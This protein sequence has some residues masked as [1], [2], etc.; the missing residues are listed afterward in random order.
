MQIVETAL[1]LLANIERQVAVVDFVL[2]C[3]CYNCSSRI[4][5]SQ[6]KSHKRVCL[7]LIAN[8]VISDVCVLFAV[9]KGEIGSLTKM[10]R[11]RQKA[12]MFL[13]KLKRKPRSRLAR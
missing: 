8:L 13:E 12:F 9:N 5:L 2:S 6:F 10:K 4:M 3:R 7:H 11:R 1:Y